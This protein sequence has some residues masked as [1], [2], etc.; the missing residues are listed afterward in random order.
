MLSCDFS[1]MKSQRALFLYKAGDNRERFGQEEC[2]GPYISTTFA[3]KLME[4][5]E[6]GAKICQ[7]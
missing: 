3:I 6:E 4:S 1:V 5:S 2:A 7:Q